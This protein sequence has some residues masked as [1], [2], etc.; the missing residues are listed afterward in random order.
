MTALIPM[1]SFARA[2]SRLAPALSRPA[3]ARLARE[4]FDHVVHTVA[5]K[6][7]R[8]FVLTECDEVARLARR[9]GATPLTV[10]P[11]SSLRALVEPFVHGRTLVV[12]ADLPALARDDLDAI[13]ALLET[14]ALVA[15]PDHARRGTSV[16]ALRRSRATAFGRHDS[17]ARH[18]ALGAAPFRAIA[19]VDT[20]ADL[21]RI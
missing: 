6:I 7:A 17:F 14:H 19:D 9:R 5:G 18:L 13:L 1:K 4:L 3:R 8:T 2:K 21:A 12:M 10:A 20:P 15:A 16:L 11:A